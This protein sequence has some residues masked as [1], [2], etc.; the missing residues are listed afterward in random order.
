M[1]VPFIL[2][3]TGCA[4]EPAEA[5]YAAVCVDQ[6]T[7]VRVE[8]DRCP[9]GSDNTSMAGPNLWYFIGRPYTAP[10]VGSKITEGSGSYAR[11]S[12][13]VGAAVRTGGFGFKGGVGG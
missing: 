7:E 1:T 4:D 13:S 5:D 2:A 11:P 3:V 6:V 9:E 12:G 8:D 10:A